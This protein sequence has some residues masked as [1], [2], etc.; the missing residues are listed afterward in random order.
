ALRLRGTNL[1]AVRTRGVF[2]SLL[3]LIPN[4][5]LVVITVMGGFAVIDGGLSIGGLVAF[6][7]YL[8]ML[9]F[10]LELLGWVLAMGEEAI[11]AAERVYEVFDTEPLIQD[12]PGATEL[13]GSRGR[14]TFENVSLRYGEDRDWVLRHV[15]LDIAPGETVAL[16]GRTG[17]GKTSL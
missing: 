12:R 7:A 2:W 16:V 5:N 6:L 3:D 1:Q 11:T 8:G 4:L 17:C 13:A 10:P 15:D 9:V 14:I